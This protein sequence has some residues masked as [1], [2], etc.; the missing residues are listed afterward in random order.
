MPILFRCP[1]CNRRL[2]VGS[3]KAGKGVLC[4]KCN[5]EVTVP[6]PEDVEA[7]AAMAGA[8]PK[9]DEPEY[10]EF[11]FE[12]GPSPAR[13][14]TAPTA[15]A[16]ASQGFNPELVTISRRALYAQ[17][18][19]IATVGLFAFVLGFLLGGGGKSDTA[20]PA[21]RAT[22]PVLIQGRLQYETSL[23]EQLDDAGSVVIAFP[24]GRYP[25]EKLMIEGLAPDEPAPEADSQQIRAIQSLGGVYVRTDKEGRFQFEVAEPGEYHVLLLSR[26]TRRSNGVQPQ[27]ADL[28]VLGRFF[29]LAPDLLSSR[30]YVW[31]VV[32]FAEANTLAHNFGVTGR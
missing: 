19:L 7:A 4:P 31:E 14:T 3:Q 5:A 15:T 11:I 10:T 25:D 23:G 21:A 30:K 16:A 13:S 12:D 8:P 29:E 26:S 1:S 2:S 17:G 20:G 27:P 22:G 9:S 6:R 24:R 32:D 18:I 28:A